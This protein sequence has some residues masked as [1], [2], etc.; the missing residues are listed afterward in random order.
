MG[1]RGRH[2]HPFYQLVS[3]RKTEASLV[4]EWA[5]GGISLT[6]QLTV[7]LALQGA[8]MMVENFLPLLA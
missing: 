6:V 7:S 2:I 5:F 4:T 1:G 3:G 8:Q